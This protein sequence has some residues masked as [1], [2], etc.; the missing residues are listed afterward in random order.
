MA[1]VEPLL[2][3]LFSSV[4]RNRYD[5]FPVSMMCAWSVSRSSIALQSLA[6]GNIVVHSENGR[7][8][9]MITAACSARPA[10]TWNSNSAADSGI[11]T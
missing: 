4:L 7:F 1:K 6:L 9:V 8:V 10:I 2:P 11:F 3:F 5:S